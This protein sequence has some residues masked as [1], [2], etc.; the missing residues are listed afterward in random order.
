MPGTTNNLHGVLDG[1][2]MFLREKDLAPAAHRP[3]LVRWARE[4]LL[5][6]QTHRGYSFEVMAMLLG[7]DAGLV[8]WRIRGSPRPRPGLLK[9]WPKSEKMDVNVRPVSI[10]MVVGPFP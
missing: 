7:A 3:Y 2:S 9:M 8:G 4:F 10:P 5:F 6:A 1:Y